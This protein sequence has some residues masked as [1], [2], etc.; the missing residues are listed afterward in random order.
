MAHNH[1]CGSEQQMSPDNRCALARV[2]CSCAVCSCAS[3][4]L[5]EPVQLP[6]AVGDSV[7]NET[8][9]DTG[10]G[11]ENQRGQTKPDLCLPMLQRLDHCG[12]LDDRQDHVW[13]AP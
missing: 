3:V 7:S 4:Q 1:T 5:Q 9:R 6:G 10:K 2:M 8:M 12:M 11:K 13:D